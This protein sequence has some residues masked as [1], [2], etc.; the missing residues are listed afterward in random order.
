MLRA[1]GRSPEMDKV[2]IVSASMRRSFHLR[3]VQRFSASV[4]RYGLPGTS[5]HALHHH[6]L[7]AASRSQVAHSR[8]VVKA[9]PGVVFQ[10]GHLQGVPSRCAAS[11]HFHTQ[12]EPPE[13][14]SK[15]SSAARG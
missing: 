8:Q 15:F 6:R 9:G 1:M 11:P 5:R 13:R 3:V 10:P 2:S 4:S 7:S 12:I 14:C